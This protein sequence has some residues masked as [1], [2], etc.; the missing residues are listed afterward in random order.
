MTSSL[1]LKAIGFGLLGFI[2]GYLVMT[3]AST[4]LFNIFDMPPKW[5]GSVLNVVM[6]LLPAFSGF[7]ATYFAR[8]R[9]TLHGLIAG[10][11]CVVLLFLVALLFIPLSAAAP[12]L[13]LLAMLIVW[14]GTIFGS[15]ARSRRG[16]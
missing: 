14:L 7:V 2:C 4:V 8:S 15:Y 13:L 10:G 5:W 16:P 3:A 6:N 1:D 9:P 11:L 12:F